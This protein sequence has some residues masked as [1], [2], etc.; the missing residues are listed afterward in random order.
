[1]ISLRSPEMNGAGKSFVRVQTTSFSAQV[2]ITEGG[3][4]YK[5]KVT[6]Y[7]NQIGL[8]EGGEAC[9]VAGGAFFL[10]L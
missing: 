3:K 10:L 7:A 9:E 8:V 6:S 4:I 1:M 5:G 2:E